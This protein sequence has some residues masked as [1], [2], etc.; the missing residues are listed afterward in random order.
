MQKLPIDV[1]KIIEQN[2]NWSIGFYNL[3]GEDGYTIYK[4]KNNKK[5]YK[6]CIDSNGMI[7]RKRFTIVHE[8]GHI[9]L[10]HFEQ[11]SNRPLTNYEAYVLDKEAD[12]FAGEILMPYKYMLEY[13]NW[14]IKGLAYKFHVSKQAAKIRLE[15]LQN[16]VMFIRDSK[17]TKNNE[18]L[19]DI[20]FIADFYS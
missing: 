13:Y 17:Y 2:P 16:D 11:Y 19:N 1:Y 8:I 5:K 14:S 9:I 7:E 15:V 12:M 20:N 18:I 10:G 6:I 3:Y 4:C